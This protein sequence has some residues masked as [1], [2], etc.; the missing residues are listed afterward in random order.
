MIEGEAESIVQT[1]IDAA[2]A[3]DTQAAK[4]LLDR[5]LPKCKQRAVVVD[6]FDA[7]AVLPK[8]A[9]AILNAVANGAITAGEGLALLEVLR[10]HTRT[11]AS[12]ESRRQN[13]QFFDA[14]ATE[15]AEAE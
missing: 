13:A 8:Q 12:D 10:A 2:K 11:I 3:G 5:V 4:A 7:D 14:F 1:L 15:Q 6:G 9:R